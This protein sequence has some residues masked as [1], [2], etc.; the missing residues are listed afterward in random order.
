[1]FRKIDQP[2]MKILGRTEIGQ[3]SNLELYLKNDL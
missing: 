1:M 2:R 3:Y